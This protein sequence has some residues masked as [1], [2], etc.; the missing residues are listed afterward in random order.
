MFQ[1]MSFLDYG[2]TANTL[3]RWREHTFEEHLQAWD[4]WDDSQTINSPIF[5]DSGGFRLM[6]SDTFG[7][8]PTEGGE[9]NEWGIYTNPDSILKLQVDFG[10]D[11][12]ATLDY[13]IPPDL[14]EDE[15]DERME[16]SIESAVRCLKLIDDPD[17]IEILANEDE[18]SVDRLKARKEAGEDPLVFVAIH[19]HDHE[20]I[21]W[22]VSEFLER[23]KEE[24][25]L[26]QFHG[27]AI[28]SLVPLRSKTD[29]LVDIVQGATEAIGDRDDIALH[30]FGI[31][32][33]QA[34]LLSLLGVDT[35]DCSSHMQTARFKKYLVPGTWNHVKLEDIDDYLIEGEWPCDVPGCPLCSETTELIPDE[36]L[37][38]V[39]SERGISPQKFKELIYR[40]PTY[41]QD[42]F[43]K[44]W[45]Y[46]LLARHNFSVYN[47]EMQRVRNAIDEN[48]LLDY[49]VEWARKDDQ[50]ERGLKRAQLRNPSLEADL[51][52]REAYDLLIGS[53]VA[54]DQVKLSEFGD[55]FPEL[56]S[57]RIS[58]RYGPRDFDITNKDYDPNRDDDPEKDILLVIPCSQ[59][60]PYADSRTHKAVFN[61]LEPVRDRIHKVTVSGMYGPVPETEEEA[62]P[63]MEYE[64]V[65]AKQDTAQ[66]ELITERLIDYLEAHGDSFDTIVGYAVSKQYRQVMEKAFKQYGRG[67][68]FP[69]DPEILGFKQHY[70]RE[71]I[72][73]LQEYLDIP[74]TELI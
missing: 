5:I 16:R 21:H 17:K 35:Y 52:A 9:E 71:N 33:K 4:E 8:A 7:E 60:K 11:I 68:V 36:F 59:R 40:E 44:G 10:G 14:K 45:L 23:A 48:R 67:R 50:I 62:K 38:Y 30:V 27:F 61:R 53:E 26:D 73:E 41:G 57:N 32:G 22:Y 37:S 3:S 29:V 20:T 47:R 42:G 51:E 49:V 54:T 70:K 64:Y 13:P 65:L 34:S 28:G 19:G 24:N 69:T 18:Q 55:E 1:A 66:I 39:D 43:T 58:L 6:N 15:Q 56:E 12:F 72:R 31:G 46:G 25:V 63:V 2:V 74:E